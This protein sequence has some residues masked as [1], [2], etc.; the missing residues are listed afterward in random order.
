MRQVIIIG[1]GPAG[2]V[3]AEALA[4]AG[5][6]VTLF[7]EH[8]AWEKP[9]GGGL[10]QKAIRA[11]PF[12]LDGPYPKKVVSEVEL[13]SGS[14]RP[15]R[16]ALDEP[17]VIYSR[18]VLNGLLLDRAERSGCRI[19]RGRVSELHT[20]SQRPRV[21]A[22]G[23]ELAA[24]FVVVAAG[25]RNRLLPSAEPLEP[26]DLEQTLGYYVPGDSAVLKIKFLPGFRG[27]LWSFP[28]PG[29][30]S[31][32]ICGKL[33]E[34]SS[35]LLRRHLEAYLD[36][37]RLSRE[38]AS[39]FSHLLPSPRLG[40]LRGRNLAGRNWALVGDAAAM[41]DSITGEGLYYAMR[42]GELLASALAA[43]R[44]EDYPIR[45]RAELGQ[46]L[47]RAA[48]LAPRFY[49][50]T[51]LGGAITARTV[52]FARGSPTFR[53]LLAALFSG[54]QD[55]A[56]LKRRLWRQLPVSLAEMAWSFVAPPA[57]RMSS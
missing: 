53:R 20:E 6:A 1:G 35:V 18:R 13:K 12:L 3:C 43:G 55:Y 4:G 56:T 28:R 27:Y 23:A 17:L 21:V 31:V 14:G 22:D 47:E 29:H 9:C 42:S 25:A 41:V 34:T 32:G 49:F 37:E 45:F 50:E 33:D 57:D 11:Y 40:T 26:A 8:L 51:F 2:A 19:V 54:T 38:G 5:L 10:T 52:D 36:E 44:P 30:L 24:E 16:L 15:A 48:A 39:F 46:E 7:D